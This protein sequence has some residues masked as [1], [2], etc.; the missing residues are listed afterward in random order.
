L[1]A[2]FTDEKPARI[3]EIGAVLNDSDEEVP[4]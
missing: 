1:Q 3:E 2:K 4:F